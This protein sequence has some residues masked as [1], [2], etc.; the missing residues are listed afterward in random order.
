MGGGFKVCLNCQAVE[1]LLIQR[2]KGRRPD[3]QQLRLCPRGMAGW[4]WT[5]ATRARGPEG[6]REVLT[7]SLK[8]GASRQASREG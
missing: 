3:A 7:E 4:G 1:L 8:G 5:R 6:R 2:T